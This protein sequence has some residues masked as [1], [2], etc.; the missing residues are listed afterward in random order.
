M[1]KFRKSRPTFLAAFLG[2]LVHAIEC[3]AGIASV[4]SIEIAWFLAALPGKRSCSL[5]V[6]G[7][8]FKATLIQEILYE[9][10]HHEL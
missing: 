3:G 10:A 6:P 9:A 8:K 7:S 2:A 5:R 4:N 1:Y